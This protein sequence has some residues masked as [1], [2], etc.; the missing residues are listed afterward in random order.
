MSSCIPTRPEASGSDRAFQLFFRL[1]TFPFLGMAGDNA[2]FD[3]CQV[4]DD[5]VYLQTGFLQNLLN[6]IR[7]SCSHFD[8]S[9]TVPFQGLAKARTQGAKGCQP[10]NAPVQRR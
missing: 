10:I 2:S 4:L 6:V 5:P 8:K 3:A 1:L 7:L 9:G